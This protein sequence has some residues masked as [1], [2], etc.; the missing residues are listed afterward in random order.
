MSTEASLW[1]ILALLSVAL[2]LVIVTARRGPWSEPPYEPRRL[3]PITVWVGDEPV[4][5]EP[6]EFSP[7]LHAIGPVF[8]VDM[9]GKPVTGLGIPAGTYLVGVTSAHVATMSQAQTR[10]TSIHA[11]LRLP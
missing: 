6:T 8:S 4:T 5:V 3:P 10:I 9:I 1:A 2:V 11:A 7:T